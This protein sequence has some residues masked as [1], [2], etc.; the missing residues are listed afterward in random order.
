MS[1]SGS[2]KTCKTDQ[3]WAPRSES[4]RVL[5]PNL[6]VCPVWK[7]TDLTGRPVSYDSFM[8]KTAGCNLSA[9]RVLVENFL[10]PQYMTYISLDARGFHND[11]LEYGDENLCAKDKSN[12]EC[13]EAN[14][15]TKD[16]SQIPIKTGNFNVNPS[17]ANITARCPTFP[18]QVAQ[19]LAD[20]NQKSRQKQSIQHYKTGNDKR[21]AS[22]NN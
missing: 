19:D 3:A 4:A 2:V 11:T 16:L 18:Y 1:L 9:D 13:Y 20:E 15:R 7:G 5:D 12:Y 8:T 21:A 6:M 22:G 17:G 14:L 10:R